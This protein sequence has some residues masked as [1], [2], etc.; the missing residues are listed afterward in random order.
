MFIEIIIDA[1]IGLYILLLVL[2][3]FVSARDAYFNPFFNGVYRATD[4][5]M[6]PIYK[7]F[8]RKPVDISG[9][10]FLVLIPI[11]L[12]ITINGL[13]KGLLVP[14]LPLGMSML[15]SFRR[16]FDFAF[17]AYV[18]LILI[19]S[20]FY[21]YARYPANPFIRTGFK[22]VAPVY[23]FIGRAMPPLKKWPGISAF[24]IGLLIHLAI[25]FAFLYII[26]AT[27]KGFLRGHPGILAIL[28]V[29]YSLFVLLLLASFFTWMIIIGALMSWI[30]PDPSNPI[31]EII[32]LLSEPINRPFRRII[33]SIGGIDISPIF[34]ILALQLV[35]QVGA[36]L[37]EK[38]FGVVVRPV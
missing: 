33:P 17:Q 5:V 11:L 8:R 26:N 6:K 27:G 13:L 38:I 4:P 21:N 31:V 36:R 3:M 20:V 22:I 12:L 23:G 29:R 25:S 34:S 30:S 9:V 1:I 28:S 10:D 19:F 7:V 15:D 16:S 18:V 35:A 24:F 32:R 37:L 2:R 14:D